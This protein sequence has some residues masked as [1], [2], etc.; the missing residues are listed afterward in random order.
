M[1]RPRCRTI[2]GSAVV[3][4]L[5]ALAFPATAAF[6]YE[7]PGMARIG[8]VASPM[9]AGSNDFL[10][11]DSCTSSTFCMAVGDF[12]L[13]GHTPAMSETLHGS[14]WVAESVPSP[15]HGSDIFANEVSCASPTS[16]LFVG[17]HRAGRGAAADLAEAWNGTSWQIVS[18]TGPTGSAFSG[19]NNVACPTT[20]FCLTV[21]LAG[22][23][24]TN[25][26]TS[27][28]WTNG[29]TW[30]KIAVPHPHGARTSELGGMACF[31]AQNCMAVGNYSIASG[32][33]LAFATRWHN[34]RW[35]LLT[36]PS[37]AG[38]KFTALNGVSCAAATS[39]V[40]VGNTEDNSRRQ[41]FHAVAEIWS[42]GKWRISTLRREPSLFIGVSCPSRTHCFASGSTFPGALNVAH[43]LIEAWNGRTWTVQHTVQ[44][45]APHHADVLPHVSC[46]SR[47]RCEAV[48]F[49]LN[50]AAS[51]SDQT[52]AEMWNGHRWTVQAT[53][54]P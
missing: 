19:L 15:S 29:S 51:N 30:K 38:Q 23:G 28:T 39:C 52:L 32:K 43:P 54:N 16:C 13:N 46:V 8:Q 42:G 33:F 14:K 34:G 48:G 31:N 47:S 41:L 40:A 1:I 18:D 21:G 36:A 12:N 4:A 20:S 35:S 26:D 27:F 44:T 17:D 45:F 22:R 53:A 24:K 37:V 6:A 3:S 2:V 10:N 7:G 9:A 5:I 25:Q 49:R 11:S 50:P